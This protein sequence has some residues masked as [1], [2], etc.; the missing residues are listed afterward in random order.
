MEKYEKMLYSQLIVSWNFMVIGDATDYLKKWAESENVELI[1]MD[2]K[3]INDLRGERVVHNE[4]AIP[5][6]DDKI[7]WLE[8]VCNHPGK[9]Y[10]MLIYADDA[11]IRTVNALKSYV[12]NAPNNLIY[13]VIYRDSKKYTEPSA[14]LRELLSPVI[15]WGEKEKNTLS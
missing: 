14:S 15:T 13:G 12:E 5:Y 9:K 1:S 4:A 6:Y 10:L 2:L 11:D 8:E 3:S 7:W